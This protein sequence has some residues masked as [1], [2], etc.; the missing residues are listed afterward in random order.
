MKN[1]CVLTSILFVAVATVSGCNK[2]SRTTDDAANE[3]GTHVHADGTVHKDSESEEGHSHDNPPHGG[4]ITVWGV[5]KYHLEFT[6]DHDKQE[7]TVYILGDDVKTAL[8]IATDEMTLA[9]KDPSFQVVLTASPQEGDPD[10]QSSRFVGNHESLRIVQEYEGAIFGKI[11]DT[12]YSGNFNE[13]P[14]DH[15]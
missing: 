11:G 6:V 4:T 10:G 14:H 1:Y 3:P 15:D 12:P 7:A 13:G 2:D 8:P 9:I 5:E